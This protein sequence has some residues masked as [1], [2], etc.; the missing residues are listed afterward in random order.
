MSILSKSI[1][2]QN[3]IV[4]CL[5]KPLLIR[6]QLEIIRFLLSKYLKFI[7][8]SQSQVL[9]DNYTIYNESTLTGLTNIN[10]P[11]DHKATKASKIPVVLR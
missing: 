6:I 8:S 2:S 5:K 7:L 10:R 11:R 1:L 9:L 3:F 4:K